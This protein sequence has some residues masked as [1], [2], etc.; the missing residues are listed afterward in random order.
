MRARLTLTVGLAVGLGSSG[1]APLYVNLGWVPRVLGAVLAVTAGALVARRLR[2]PALGQPVVE[3]AALAAYTA[4]V[5]TPGTLTARV[6]PTP[7]SVGALRALAAA[8]WADVRALSAPVPTHPGLVVLAVLG[9]GGLTVLVDLLAV[10]LA[11]PAVAG[12]P[13]LLLY[14]LPST[15]RPGGT[16]VVAFGLG[17][18]GWLTLLLVAGNDR[19]GRWGEHLPLV[20]GTA[21][22]RTGQGATG[23]VGRRIG[24]AA[25]G[26][27][28][29]L[30]AGLP[31][32]D[33]RLLS[34]SHGSSGITG[35]AARQSTTYNPITTLRGQLNQPA[36]TEVL[37]YTTTDPQPDYLR[38]T[39][40]DTFDGTRWSASALL[41][42]PVQDAVGRGIALPPTIDP[43]RTVTLRDRIL[44]RTLTTRW[45]PVP[46][47][48]TAV[49][50]QGPWVWDRTS[51][52]VFSTAQNTRD[53]RQPYTVTAARVTVTP[54]SLTDTGSRPRSIAEYADPV[55]LTPY[56]A[57][58][59]RLA[60]AGA[61]TDFA[62]VLA[63]QQYFRNAARFTYST[64][65]DAP[66]LDTDDALEWFLRNG[67]GFCEQ[68]ASAMAAMVR[69]LGLPARVAV[70]FT[71]GTRSDSGAYVVTTSDA[72][73]WPEVW[74]AATGWLRF[75]PTPRSGVTVVPAYARPQADP[76]PGPGGDLTVVPAPTGSAGPDGK[77]LD[78]LDPRGQGTEPAALPAG[79]T[80]GGT[81]WPSARRSALVLAL[82]CLPL[83]AL[84]A[85]ARRRRRLHH[86]TPAS[87]WAQLA[88]DAADLGHRWTT[89]ESPRT[90][91]TRL[92]TTFRLDPTAAGALQRVVQAVE[93]ARYARPGPGAAPTAGGLATGLAG[94]VGL[95]RAGLRRAAGPA[96]RWRARLLPP[97]TVR[98]L[99]AGIGGR[100]ADL[101][102]G[103][104]AAVS[105]LGRL[106][107]RRPA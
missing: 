14:V 21:A 39:T 86:A 74:F 57:Q 33:A 54:G 81:G 12:L 84:L 63:L 88:D 59:V 41:A 24:A 9:V 94:D 91:A 44:I 55:T 26:V 56:V 52:T 103:A 51:E 53:L 28:L 5:F 3:L 2:V 42:D 101:F 95:V 66:R 20:D 27:A 49:T 1:L 82:L 85:R 30:P 45:L 67:K 76:V 89:A 13:L 29:V 36:P 60:T 11:S 100:V 65:A 37:R 6:L 70:G 79:N 68:Y 78:R 23:R 77:N 99:G 46:A 40:L 16:G 104:D 32:L 64:H 4:L 10:L 22:D 69:S 34:G 62:K 73:A 97:V 19:L 15:V 7:A 35:R 50:L 98:W 43:V 106:V 17:A 96:Q 102:D 8:G 25:L 87:A 61:T 72:H 93:R 105:G 80:P 92:Q 48:P 31:G 47:L 38:L 107:R 58:E 18:A 75:E 83:P 71:H 90:A